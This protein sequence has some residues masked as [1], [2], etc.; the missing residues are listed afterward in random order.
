MIKTLC[1]TTSTGKS[2][3][4]LPLQLLTIT[5]FVDRDMFMR[6]C[7]HAVG[8]RSKASSSP[9]QAAERQTAEPDNEM[10]VDSENEM[11][12]N[13][14]SA[15]ENGEMDLPEEEEETNSNSSNSE[16]E[17]DGEDDEEDEEEAVEEEQEGVDDGAG[18]IGDDEEVMD[19]LGYASL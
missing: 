4:S 12:H 16:D 5:S 8:H 3:H 11:N 6:Y 14:G 19:S 15:A 1:I 13:N 9:G 2:F 17:L 18:N 10:D 7:N